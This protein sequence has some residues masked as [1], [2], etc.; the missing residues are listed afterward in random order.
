MR[1]GHLSNDHFRFY[2]VAMVGKPCFVREHALFAFIYSLFKL[3]AYGV[4]C[5]FAGGVILLC[6]D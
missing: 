4:N 6:F 2:G 1:N 3:D 5:W